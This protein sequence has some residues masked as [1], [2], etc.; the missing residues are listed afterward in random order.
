MKG[1]TLAALASL[2][3]L[4]VCAFGTPRRMHSRDAKS[5][6]PNMA[7]LEQY[8]MDRDAEIALARTAAPESISGDATVVVLGRHG[9]ETAVQGKNGFVCIVERSWNNLFDSREFWNPKVRGAD[10]LNPPAARSVLA[11]M[12]LRARLALAGLSKTE[13]IANIKAGY[14]KKELPPLEPGSMSYMMSKGSY[15]NDDGSHNMAHLM[16]YTELMDGANWGADL[17][18]S[19][20][21]LIPVFR[22]VP[23]P[24]N[25]FIVPT[26]SWSD[27][28]PQ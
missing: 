13:M 24:V 11:I 9:Y 16:F 21:H 17:P 19:P 15:L 27:G 8:L 20:V 28:T 3:M 23:E 6:Y 1:K 12:Y 7:P 14:D 26:R 4:L 10:C 22:G 25:V 18:K 2:I 5:P